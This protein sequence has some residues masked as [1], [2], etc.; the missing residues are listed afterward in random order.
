[1]Q[2]AM[3]LPIR[4]SN[5]SAINI[6]SIAAALNIMKAEISNAAPLLLRMQEASLSLE[7]V[8]RNSNFVKEIAHH[9]ATALKQSAYNFELAIS[10]IQEKMTSLEVILNRNAIIPTMLLTVD[11][12]SAALYVAVNGPEIN[13]P[14]AEIVLERFSSNWIPEGATV[15][16]TG[17]ANRRFKEEVWGCNSFD[18]NLVRL[19]RE[20]DCWRLKRSLELIMNVVGVSSTFAVSRQ[21][22]ESLALIALQPIQSLLDDGEMKW[23]HLISKNQQNAISLEIPRLINS[24]LY[25][26]K[27]KTIIT[28][29][30]LKIVYELTDP[31]ICPQENLINFAQACHFAYGS[32]IPKA[33]LWLPLKIKK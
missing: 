28:F 30:A 25:S 5:I 22:F 4:E 27:E 9:E 32:N 12:I 17:I 18:G 16:D 10:E 8:I 14:L 1:M 6:P 33:K 20:K 26:R 31:D 23:T 2:E 3:I 29:N 19:L 7:R 13:W 11:D 15:V 21:I 24:F